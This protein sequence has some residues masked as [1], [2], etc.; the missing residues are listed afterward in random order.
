MNR[1]PYTT[2][3]EITNQPK[4]PP[5]HIPL[6]DFFSW[7]IARRVHMHKAYMRLIH[8]D[9]WTTYRLCKAYTGETNH[10]KLP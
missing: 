7:A 3:E 8:G 6:R 4:V 9:P 1:S 5:G 10:L 2:M